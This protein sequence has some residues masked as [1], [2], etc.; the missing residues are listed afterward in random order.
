MLN[1]LRAGATVPGTVKRENDNGR[2]FVSTD[3]Y[4]T[5][6]LMRA[7]AIPTFRDDAVGARYAVRGPLDGGNL[8]PAAPQALS[9]PADLPRIEDRG[10][11]QQPSSKPQNDR[12]QGPGSPEASSPPLRS[13]PST[14]VPVVAPA[15]QAP[16][17]LHTAPQP[18][19]QPPSSPSADQSAQPPR[20]PPRS[21][22]V[23]NVTWALD[24]AGPVTDPS[25]SEGIRSDVIQLAG[26]H[27]WS[28]REI[29]ICRAIGAESEPEQAL[30]RLTSRAPRLA[31]LVRKTIDENRKNLREAYESLRAHYGQGS[32]YTQ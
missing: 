1:T 27:N 14:S 30:R 12:P 9:A 22:V 24:E 8:M 6:L 25:L 26:L 7:G 21:E 11:D 31:Q 4:R 32:M 20:Q 16:P 15:R 13:A 29:R 10:T 5:L 18:P 28:E 3:F 17:P 23:R 2:Y 19:Q